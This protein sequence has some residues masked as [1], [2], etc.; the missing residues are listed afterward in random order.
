MSRR[1]RAERAGRRGETLAACW[2]ML[3]GW[4]VIARRVKT[5]RGEVDLVVR[6][7]RTLCFVEVKW[8]ATAA[9]LDTAI[10]LPRLRSPS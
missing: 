5:P 10:S 3:G 7:G 1:A 8:R 6:R 2:L 4:R 9:E